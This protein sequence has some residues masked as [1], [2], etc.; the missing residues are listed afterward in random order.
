MLLLEELTIVQLARCFLLSKRCKG[1]H[2]WEMVEGQR[3]YAKQP[4]KQ[5]SSGQ[6]QQIQNPALAMAVT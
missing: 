1:L 4:A 6:Q 2:I 5:H 3:L